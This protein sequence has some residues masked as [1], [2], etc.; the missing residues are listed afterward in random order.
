MMGKLLRQPLLSKKIGK[1]GL[2]HSFRKH[3]IPSKPVVCISFKFLRLSDH[4]ERC[5]SPATSVCSFEIIRITE[6]SKYHR[7]D[8][9]KSLTQ[10]EMKFDATV[11]A[12]KARTKDVNS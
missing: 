5:Y 1:L 4:R 3:W 6:R 2:F 8:G 10:A 12:C 7:T 11:N 9:S